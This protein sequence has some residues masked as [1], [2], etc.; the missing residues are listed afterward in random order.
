LHLEARG[1][2]FDIGDF[3]DA[4]ESKPLVAGVNRAHLTYQEATDPEIYL[5]LDLSVFIQSGEGDLL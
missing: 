5:D 2:F 3:I 4:L 1:R